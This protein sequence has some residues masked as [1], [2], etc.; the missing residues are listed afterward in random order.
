MSKRKLVSLIYVGT[1]CLK[2]KRGTVL[3]GGSI[4]VK[5]DTVSFYNN[6]NK[7]I[8]PDPLIKYFFETITVCINDF[9][10]NLQYN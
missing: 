10:T 5:P 8:E 6:H 9:H 3:C 7:M 4:S 1:S 2:N